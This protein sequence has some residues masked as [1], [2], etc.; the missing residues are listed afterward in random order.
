MYL[1]FRSVWIFHTHNNCAGRTRFHIHCCL[2]LRESLRFLN[3][4][5][6]TETGAVS[7]PCGVSHGNVRVPRTHTGQMRRLVEMGLWEPQRPLSSALTFCGASVGTLD[8]RGDQFSYLY[9][10]GFKELRNPYEMGG[11]YRILPK[12]QCW[13]KC[14][15]GNT[16][17]LLLSA[18]IYP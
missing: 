13:A 4:A 11:Y 1:S 16:V 9:M 2:S 12:R 18:S 5:R 14:P 3:L 17:T 15:C 8:L 6:A 7:M 10:E